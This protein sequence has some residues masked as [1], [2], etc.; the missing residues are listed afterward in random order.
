LVQHFHT[1]F[2]PDDSVT[3][4]MDV[5]QGHSQRG[6]WVH[7]PRHRTSIFVTAPLVFFRVSIFCLRIPL[8]TSVPQTP[9]V[10]P[11]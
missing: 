11:S 3:I 5:E 8:V 4:V 2:G 10:Y 7:V 9:L 6:E 1:F